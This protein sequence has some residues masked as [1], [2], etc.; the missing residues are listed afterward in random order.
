MSEE[1]ADVVAQV[2]S[3][4]RI[5]LRYLIPAIIA[6]SMLLVTSLLPFAIEYGAKQWLQDHGVETVEI[7][8]VDLNLFTGTL[9]LQ[10]LQAGDG[11]NI[12]QLAVNIDWLPLFKQVIY[13]RSFELQQSHISFHQDERGLWQLA[14]IKFEQAD[15]ENDEESTEAQGSGWL[16]VVDG[17]NI[18]DLL[19]NVNG[20]DLKLKLPVD[21]LKLSLSDLQDDE[22]RLVTELALGETDFTGFGYQLSG[23][24]MRLSGQFLFAL[25]GG[26]DIAA[27]L[28]S[29]EV[30]LAVESLKLAQEKGK[31]LATVDMIELSDLQMAGL[32]KHQLESLAISKLHL[33]PLLTG[34]GSL[35][36]ESMDVKQIDADL[37][38]QVLLSSL[39]IK[40]L[41]THAMGSVDDDIS[42]QQLEVQGLTVEPG[43]TLNLKS[44]A[45]QGFKFVQQEGK[46][47]LAAIETVNLKQFSMQGA[48]K[49]SFD[50]L[51]LSGVTLP[52]SGGES[53]GSIGSLVATGAVL[54]TNSSYHLKRLQFVDLNTTL[55]KQKNGTLRVLD[56]LTGGAK[57]KTKKEQL[58]PAGKSV[59]KVEKSKAPVVVIDELLV[60]RGSKIRYRDE[61]LFPP[62]DSRMQVKKFRFAPLD[63]SGTRYGTLDM[64]MSVGKHGE[65]SAKGKV[66]P[67]AQNLKTDLVVTLKNFDLPGF[68][69]FIESDFGKSIKTGQF[70]L[71]S[72]VLISDNKINAKNKLLIRKLELGDS[73]QP[74]KA[75]QAI[76]MPVGMALDM[77][78]DDRGDI[79]MEVPISGALDDPDININ[80][81][82]N[83]ALMSS[84]S[85]GAMTYALLAL[86]PYGSLILAADLAGDLIKQ[87][88]KP[89]LTPV[90][91]DEL[92]TEL[93]PQ[94]S[95]YISKVA[96]LLKKSEQF[97]LQ[98]CGV[99][100]RIEAEPVARPAA[101]SPGEEKTIEQPEGKSDEELLLLGQAR[102]DMVM[103]ALQQ[104]GIAT[105]RLFTCRATVDEAKEDAKPRVDL[106]LD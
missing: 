8:N 56:D 10:G 73:K 87:A 42:F 65:L 103:S 99:A 86:Q 101:V 45:M 3:S 35:K 2:K 48:D 31:L 24:A 29:E 21:T 55:I 38:G 30:E 9:V 100:T 92:E 64:Q 54:D 37:K 75:E 51:A 93:N 41:Q 6:V 98:I 58:K 89:K 57:A 25:S 15:A 76:G 61:S 70:N 12:E 39:L 84:L 60:S 1:S 16:V 44:L 95:D 105:E 7:D 72:T 43:K 5:K 19:L 53:L 96:V 83:K 20:K 102:S 62:L 23:Q 36:L 82:I 91:F 80:A 63:S 18:E 14:D 59:H 40:Q 94:M 88:A 27:S 90:V 77:L 97:R 69:G 79:E 81:I 47:K 104:H 33:S 26:R 74:G 22:Q 28:K 50:Q 4:S 52:A 49:G 17:L 78:R 68:S 71:D 11:L 32:Y 46:Q 13:I 67:R 66:W 85:A 34:A 106:I